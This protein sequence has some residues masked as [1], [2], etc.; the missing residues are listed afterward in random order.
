MID[1]VTILVNLLVVS[2]ILFVYRQYD[3]RSRALD[4]IKKFVDIAKDNLEDFIDEKT[5]EINNLAVDMEA[6]QRSSIEIIKKIDEVQQKIQN[7]SNDFAE[8]EKKIAYHDSM[9]KDLD[10]MALKVQDNIQRLQ[11][12]GKI[13][14]KL[15]KTLK[16]FNTQIDSIDSRLNTV[17]EKFD[18]KNK[19][20]LESIKVASWEKF[21]N[22]IR[23]F[24]VRMDN[25]DK[26]LSS[27]QESLLM[28]EEKKRE[29]LDRGN[30]KLD[31]E[32]KDFLLKIE[33]NIDSYNKSME[34]SFNTYETKYK[35][36]ENSIDLILE[37]AKTKINDK[38]D[39]IFTK[40]NEELQNKFGEVFIYV[41]DRSNQIREELE[42]KLSL[43]D[44]EVLSLSSVFKD[45]TYS[46]LNS[47]EET[48]RQEM[49]Q[50]EDQFSDILEQFRVQIESNVGDIYREY[51]N[52]IN[53]FDK[54]IRDRIGDS[55][56]DAN[57]K[58][59]D[60]Q[61]GV[62][63][64]L[65]DLEDDSN[66]IYVEFKEKVRDDIDSFNEDV[67]SK[68]NSIGNDLELKL[69][70][71]NTDIQGE[72]SKLDNVLHLKLKEINE[73]FVNEYSFLEENVNSKYKMLLESFN[74]KSNELETQF[75][76]KYR[77]IA[78]KFAH[79]I[80]DLNVKYDDRFSKMSEKSDYDY[81]SF[82]ITSKK[83]NEGIHSLNVFLEQ[84]FDSLRRDFESKLNSLNSDINNEVVNL[85]SHYG[86]DIG[87][88][89]REMEASKLQHEN[90]Q[91]EMQL[92]LGEM[93]SNLNKTNEEFVNLIETQRV[94]G[95]ELSE[96]IFNELSEH[97][98]KKA[99]DM[100]TNWKDE[101]IVLNKS[102]LDIKISSEELLSSTSS[103]IES[104]EKDINERLEYVISK[105]ETCEGSVLD[106]YK[107]LK[108]IASKNSEETLSG[109]KEFIDNQAEIIHDKII[110]MLNGFNEDFSNKEDIIKNKIEELNYCFKDFKIECEDV[111]NNIKTDLDGFIETRVRE[112]SEIKMD[113][114]KQVDDFLIQISQDILN[115]K[116]MLNNEIDG[117]LS[118]WQDK[119]SEISVNIENVLSSGKMDINSID[120]E[121]TLKINDLKTTFEGLENYYLEKI[122][123]FRNQGNVYADEL[124]QN[125]MSHF[126]TDTKELEENLSKKFATILNNS[127]EFVKEVDSLLKDKR[128]D[129]ASFQANIDITID[130]LNSRFNDINREI[131]EK[132]SKVISDSRGYSETLASK[133]E[134]EI[135]YEIED[136]SRRLTDK[137]DIL[138]KNMDDSIEKFKSSF[139]VSKYQVEDFEIKIKDIVGKEELRISEFLRE[140]E[141]QYKIRREEAIDY[142]KAIDNDV[143][144]LKERFMGM[145][146]ELKNNIEDKSEFLNEL[147][148]E[149]FKIIENNF[150][151]RYSTFFVES[152]GA[153]SKIRDE[154]YKILTDNDER[155]RAKIAEM[156]SNFEIIEERSKEILEFEEDLRKKIQEN[157]NNIY[158]QFNIV[159]S[160]V[161]KEMKLQFDAYMMQA[162]S[163]VND[164]IEKYENGINDKISILKAIENNFE[165]I[166]K[167]LKE[168]IGKYN[169]DLEN[170]ID[171]KY[172][173]LE[174]KYNEKH[175]LMEKAIDDK[176]NLV[177]KL[178]SN[179]Y[180][181][182]EN[183]YN[184][185]HLLVKKA[186]DDTTN[187]VE[188]LISNKYFELEDKYNEKHLLVEK[189]ID[190]K[191][192]LVEEFISNK[193][194]ELEDRYNERHLLVEKAMD[195]RVN[196]VEELISSKYSELKDRYDEKYLLVDKT[197]DDKVNLVEEFISN[198]CSEF[199]NKYNEKHLLV[200]KT[201]DDKA[202]LV[203]ELI[204][205]KYAELKDKYNEKYL[206]ID[207][208]IDDRVNLVEE[209]ISNKCSEFEDKYNEK[210]LLVEKTIDDRVNLV[211]ELVSSKYAELKDKYNE[212]YLLIDKAIDDKVNLVEELVSNKYAEL[213]DKYDEKYLL[214]DKAIDDKTNLISELIS[215][216]Y[217]ELDNKYSNMHFDVENKLDVF[218]SKLNLELSNSNE[219]MDRDI[220]EQ[221][222]GLAE[223]KVSLSNI[224]EDV[225]K[226]KEDSYHNLSSHLK[227]L[228]E[229]FFQ[230]LKERSDNLSNSLE[231]FITSSDQ[232]I[233]SLENEIIKNLEDK[234]N[235]IRD[236]RIEIEQELIL[237]KENFYLEFNN[238]FDIKRRDVENK[239]ALMETNV[240]N[241]VDEFIN[242]VDNRQSNFDSWFVKVKDD[243]V[244]WQKNTY[245]EFE[246]RSGITK[247]SLNEIKRDIDGI[248]N[249]LEI[250]KS[251]VNQR[252]KKIFEDL[253]TDIKD[254]EDRAY[255]NLKNIS[256]D[257]Q[258]K[259]LNIENTMHSKINSINEKMNLNIEELASQ[260]EIK[261]L[262]HQ[263][264]LEDK[265]SEIN[266]KLEYEY[267]LM[268][269]KIES[270]RQDIVSKF[271][272]D[273]DNF[274]SQVKLIQDDVLSL[275]E[276]VNTYQVEIERTVKES[277]DSFA[278]TL[279]EECVAFEN[280]IKRNLNYSEEDIKTL[281][282]NL[283]LKVNNIE[284]EFKDKY[285]LIIKS[286]DENISQLKLKVLNYDNEFSHFIND[287]K[288]NL[289]AYKA[290]LM[291]E[292]DDR[293][294]VI[295]TKIVNFERLGAELEKNHGLIEEVYHFKN[296]LEE[297]RKT[298]V[299][300]IELVQKYKGD[301]ESI[302]REIEDVKIRTSD[303][304]E[305][306]NDLKTHQI[307]IK[308]IK[309]DFVECLEFYT[310]FKE[311]YKK[312]TESYDEIQVYKTKLKEIK[313]E[314]D[315]ILDNYDRINNKD[316]I[317]KS[318]LESVDRNFDLINEIETKMN[319]LFKESSGFKHS[320]DE[321]RD[322]MSELL[323]NKD[324]SKEVL[325]NVQTLQ[326]MLVEIEDK[327]EHTQSVRE[328]VAKSETR[329]ENLNIAA[330]ERIK[331]LGILVKTESK[332]KDNIG[333]N[334]ATVRDSVIKL[335]RQGWSA[336][337][338]S[339]ATKLSVGEVELILELGIISKSDD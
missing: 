135:G 63:R 82:E 226:L 148:K 281:R 13:V 293:Y 306:F 254:F 109:I 183:K 213:K 100:H 285:D 223:L 272:N 228:E 123:E 20:N 68:M 245:R 152:E 165:M 317:L 131:N 182:L 19:E 51:D 295:N 263:K 292:L 95:T 312:F 149:R 53:Q 128:T 10:D 321:L 41:D 243:M 215:D 276:K 302:A 67:F 103:K 134:N 143:I 190:D 232:R 25:L 126:D 200:E 129:I 48:I 153:I 322:I 219:K 268:T 69:V 91:K 28:V 24:G 195:D 75:E 50:Y 30:L 242:L 77:N 208:A 160:D 270:E 275:S 49:R 70:N 44:N 47:L 171:F 93:K 166:E 23:D 141:Q 185:R 35:S 212:K 110:M 288:D 319:L 37:Q 157:S 230:D 120:S 216:K 196:L 224:E 176:T 122:D 107:E 99:I 159:K 339:R 294:N 327:L 113:N 62:K 130:S 16:N 1:F 186:I 222:K 6:Y 237:N 248:E 331:T 56:R 98:Q 106:K 90:W 2:L 184:E 307:D 139:D 116:D 239:I 59:A 204:S 265:I 264:D 101:L 146:S 27:Y 112:I 206:L 199:E 313:D 42:G 161:E 154:I 80:D 177:E 309:R 164:E 32:F 246:E 162:K 211:E 121:M 240:T 314:Q 22:T 255:L 194:S 258:G 257:V 39:F 94:K 104:F 203:E 92:N 301:F 235:L 328:K 326:E 303:I 140:V 218:I 172:T 55:L 18:Q 333:L 286:V 155:L 253:H 74:L 147:Y 124:L 34:E 145:I 284:S 178:I 163:A 191:V 236:F 187:L 108:D 308:G 9:L 231:N 79:D 300:E 192:N 323:A 73:K 31:N 316:S 305:V 158:D 151:E 8:V 38:E 299:G 193:C 283:N 169:S 250:V 52:K 40:L 336:L 269:S 304:I 273:R 118:V 71:I 256:D 170:V 76:S 221:L 181:E 11:V 214:V 137:I 290:S 310:S 298:L 325:G 96:H 320:L 150:D 64:L 225:L 175:L 43:V 14:D 7:K 21:D 65:D 45:N 297:L 261:F 335:M 4:K 54:D 315:T 271:F 3:R 249:D 296:K 220:K 207:K 334:N 229:D 46:R 33:S 97:I 277:Y 12:D 105:A 138:S 114:Q 117:K 57:S 168:K 180:S 324:L 115:K 156:D 259:V 179:K 282:N 17:F 234:E 102:L 119:L 89:V 144:Q 58:I 61:G 167:D 287:T 262:S 198:K 36:I 188:E 66:K 72:V 266:E 217:A 279:R 210:H 238:E 83:I 227:L 197:I 81:Q 267:N 311:R 274:E 291:G 173:E 84:N 251:S 247:E 338:I 233:K 86:E 127:E 280:D 136:I 252:T 209:F 202:N 29:I 142:R 330:E 329:L 78:D 260:V 189:A 174:N 241:R 201:I 244:H 133:L 205:S 289:I 26:N 337:E 15:S 85:K 5:K 88:F 318:T 332:Y 125:I 111:L 87:K 132:Y 60:V 278:T